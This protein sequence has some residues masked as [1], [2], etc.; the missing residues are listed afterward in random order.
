M[1]AALL[2]GGITIAAGYWDMKHAMLTSDTRSFVE[3]HL[4]VGW[5]IA[6]CLVVLTIWRWRIKQQA[7][8]P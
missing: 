4:R 3:L 6:A 5:T 7:R 1:L 2:G 8:Q